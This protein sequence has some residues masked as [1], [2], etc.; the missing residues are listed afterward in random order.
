VNLID[1]NTKI[2]EGDHL[3]FKGLFKIT[4][5]RLL[6]Y[7]MLFIS[8]RTIASDLLQDCYL[9]L[10]EIRR[11]LKPDQSVESLLFVMLRHHCL[12]YLRDRK[13]MQHKSDLDSVQENDLQH[14]FELDFTGT[15]QK[16]LEEEL[17]EAIKECIQRLPERR[18]MVFIESKQKGLKNKEVAEK[19]GISIKAVEK[20]LHL[21]QEQIRN[22]LLIRYPM[23]VL[24]ITI[25]LG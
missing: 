22:E 24:F 5:A 11:T 3:A 1:L 21:A 7:C 8:D 4:H 15:E 16:A 19:L 17:I 12:N 20:H 9:K 6:G 13:V 18:K 14:L 2:R 25:L 10:W 23:M